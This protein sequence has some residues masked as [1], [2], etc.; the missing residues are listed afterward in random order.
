M[1]CS[2]LQKKKKRK[3][4]HSWKYPEQNY[5]FSQMRIS[6]IW[7]KNWN[8]QTSL[9]V[10]V[11]WHKNTNSFQGLAGKYCNRFLPSMAKTQTESSKTATWVLPLVRLA[12]QIILAGFC[13][14]NKS[15]T[16]RA[17]KMS[18]LKRQTIP[19]AAREAR[20]IKARKVC[21]HSETILM[22]FI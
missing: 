13:P 20:K 7:C 15:K 19:A 11:S 17:Q 1:L 16:I 8:C 2:D 12:Y 4:H 18:L 5:F 10:S 21:W 3:K 6:K 22:W 9:A 14:A